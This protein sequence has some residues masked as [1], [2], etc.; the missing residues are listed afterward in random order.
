MNF[1]QISNE[2]FEFLRT[3]IGDNSFR[4]WFKNTKIIYNDGYKL[5]VPNSFVYNWIK[6]NYDN[7]I[8][9]AAKK[10]GIE[11]Q[12]AIDQNLII[13]A[14]EEQ[15]EIQTIQEFDNKF[16]FE[17]FIVGE[18]NQ[19]AYEACYRIATSNEIIFNPLFIYAP[20][21]LGKTHLMNAIVNYKRQKFPQQKIA[22]LSAE[23]FMNHFV[24]AIQTKNTMSFK[25][26]FRSVDVLLIDDFQFLGKKDA[27]QVEFFHTFNTLLEQKKQ[28]IISAD[29]APNLLPGV[30]SR[31]KSRLGW[32]MVVDIHPA[33]YELRLSIVKNKI[34]NLKLNLPDDAAALIAK[35]VDS[36]IRE[37]EGAFLRIT[38]YSEWLKVPITTDLVETVLRDISPTG[39]K[40]PEE[41]I[42]EICDFLN[43]SVEE[44]KGG[45]RS[46]N[47]VR[48]RQKIVFILRSVGKLSYV[49]I[50]KLIG[51]KDH[52]T[53]IYAETQAKKFIKEDNAF[54]SEIETL[55]RKVG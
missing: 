36:S 50:A 37:L 16:S 15:A 4:D 8:Q 20:V 53:I 6:N 7:Y 27:T 41:M 3:K 25:D 49:Q 1:D 24:K 21:G 12:I 43:V 44:L 13:E 19:I 47:L 45:N 32:G 18:S 11:I 23:Q 30:E 33:N 54:A 29:V 34:E 51:N 31:L 38:K 22:Y 55:L 46:R 9:E 5:A 28:L 26:D 35:K 52:T 14:K 10:I 39:K 40:S 42:K 17:N 2:L 48:A